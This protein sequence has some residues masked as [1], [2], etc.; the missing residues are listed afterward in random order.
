[1]CCT[2]KVLEGPQ[3]VNKCPVCAL[4][5][6]PFPPLSKVSSRGVPGL[7]WDPAQHMGVLQRRP[8]PVLGTLCSHLHPLLS[9]PGLWKHFENQFKWVN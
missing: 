2:Q 4:F 9:S 3:S 5:P 1:M 8:G 6:T 7:C